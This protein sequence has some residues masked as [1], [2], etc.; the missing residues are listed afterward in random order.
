MKVGAWAVVVEVH[1]VDIDFVPTLCQKLFQVLM[2]NI[3]AG[4]GSF[5]QVIHS[6]VGDAKKTRDG[7][8]TF[9]K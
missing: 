9:Y 5:S 8:G 3:C 1:S 2:G 4:H 7:C 6:L